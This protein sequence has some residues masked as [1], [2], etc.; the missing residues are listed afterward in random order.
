MSRFD[1]GYR[2]RGLQRFGRNGPQTADLA[3][4]KENTVVAAYKIL[5][6]VDIDARIVQ[7]GFAVAFI[8]HIE[9][10]GP[11]GIAGDPI[12][13][14]A[15]GSAPD[16]CRQQQRQKNLLHRFNR[17]CCVAAAKI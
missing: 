5:G 15:G 4:R 11:F 12:I 14:G 17:F 1:G 7:H 8:H 3:E 6:L 9:R 16:D 2:R 13:V 10:N